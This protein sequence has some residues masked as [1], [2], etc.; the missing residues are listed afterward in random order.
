[1]S[2][3]AIIGIKNADGSITGAWCW[4]DGYDIKDMLLKS[5]TTTEDVDFLLAQG[6]FET[7]MTQEGAIDYVDFLKKNGIVSDDKRFICYKGSF[8]MSDIRHESRTA[9]IYKDIDAASG[10]D[11]NVLYLFE[12]EQW[13]M[14]KHHPASKEIPVNLTERKNRRKT[15]KVRAK[16][17]N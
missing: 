4:C 1:M 9:E 16:N 8:I 14:Y 15:R 2:T 5:F 17:E 6:M 11:I 7:I 12:N 13:L 10:Q 3:R